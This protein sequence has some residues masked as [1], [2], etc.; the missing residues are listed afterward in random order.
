MTTASTAAGRAATCEPA[1]THEIQL[2]GH[3]DDHWSTRLDCTLVRNDDGSTTLTVDVVD[4]AQLHGLLARI[5]DV[6]VTL[7]SLGPS[8]TC[9]TRPR[10]P[11]QRLGGCST[12][13][14][15]GT[16]TRLRRCASCCASASRTWWSA[17]WWRTASSATRPRG[18]W[19]ND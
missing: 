17:G 2:A 11:R 4:Q 1:V 14:T 6:G 13:P 18:G 9:P 8:A 3:L 19:W 7:L 12:P 10:A 15:W 16:G 5:R